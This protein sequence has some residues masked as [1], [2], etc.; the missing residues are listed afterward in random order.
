MNW[1]VGDGGDGVAGGRGFFVAT[2][3]D[4]I[5]KRKKPGRTPAW[6]EAAGSAIKNEGAEKIG[7][8]CIM[9]ALTPS[10]IYTIAVRRQL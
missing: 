8:L 10:F 6:R 3:L 4:L 1:R 2:R 9:G 5:V 7:H